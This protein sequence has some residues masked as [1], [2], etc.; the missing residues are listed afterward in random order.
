MLRRSRP[1]T[2][3]LPTCV[4]GVICTW[5]CQQYAWLVVLSV[6]AFRDANQV[7]PSASC[8]LCSAASQAT[9]ITVYTRAASCSSDGAAGSDADPTSSVR[10]ASSAAAGAALIVDD[11][12]AGEAAAV[13][14]GDAAEAEAALCST[15]ATIQY[16]PAASTANVAEDHL[17][18]CFRPCQLTAVEAETAA[19]LKVCTSKADVLE[20]AALDLGTQET[21]SRSSHDVDMKQDSTLVQVVPPTAP[22]S[23]AA[24]LVEDAVA[25]IEEF[26]KSSNWK[27][28]ILLSEA[29]D[30]D[31]STEEGVEPPRK[32]SRFHTDS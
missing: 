28:R 11:A 19:V 21:N 9:D 14:P 20:G 17:Q 6:Q 7:D 1:G 26:N 3:T 22:V 8:P 23:R 31:S 29:S 12:A 13:I 5:Q 27:K 2:V 24:A 15:E 18:H 10:D 30:C 32:S 25:V 16:S 4:A